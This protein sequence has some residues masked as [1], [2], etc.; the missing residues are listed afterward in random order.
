MP[1]GAAD[2]MASASGARAAGRRRRGAPSALLCYLRRTCLVVRR[3]PPRRGASHHREP[4]SRRRPRSGRRRKRRDRTPNQPPRPLSSTAR[5]RQIPER[6]TS[7]DAPS[8][9]SATLASTRTG[10]S[11]ETLP[12][13]LINAPT[14][15]DTPGSSARS[16]GLA[17]RCEHFAERGFLR[18]RPRP[19]RSHRGRSDLRQD[20]SGL[21]P[22]GDAW[23][24]ARGRQAVTPCPN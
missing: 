12:A 14:A 17:R 6:A 20:P 5:A 23:T 4:R 9:V 21:R 10:R 8:G 3:P 13:R 16:S 7:L 18:R 22:L 2:R 15:L 19:P 1:R 24:P 11:R